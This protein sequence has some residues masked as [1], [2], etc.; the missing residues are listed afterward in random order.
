LTA[1]RDLYMK[2]AEGCLLVYS[3][4]MKSSFVDV[5]EIIEQLFRVK[6]SESVPII[7]VG[8]KCDMERERTV[9]REEGQKL[10][11]SLP[12]AQFMETSARDKVNVDACFIA[13]AKQVMNENGPK[14]N[15]ALKKQNCVLS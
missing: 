11:S 6:D 14:S 13:L 7:L 3:I 15:G 8:N 4:T 10:A 5:Q 1:M 9:S 2:K 12:N